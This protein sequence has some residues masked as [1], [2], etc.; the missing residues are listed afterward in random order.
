MVLPLIL[1][2][3]GCATPT[4]SDVAYDPATSGLAADNVQS[5]IDAEAAERNALAAEQAGS[6]AS[7]ATL[8]TETASLQTSVTALETD[9]ASIDLLV[10]ALDASL[11][12]VESELA[13]VQAAMACPTGTTAT[14]GIC[15]DED[16]RTP[17]VSGCSQFLEASE[18]CAAEGLRL[19]T[20]SE[21]H[22]ACLAAP[23]SLNDMAGNYEIVA[24][25]TS[26]SSF[27][28]AG[29]L[30]CNNFGE[31]SCGTDGNIGLA[32]AYRCCL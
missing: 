22:S 6:A 19:C 1:A 29:S 7:L 25:L 17:S 24:D 28:V 21:W 16:E 15:I 4:A 26:A 31:A 13:A 12:S 10:A 18:A 9:V 20:L 3:L 30:G 23:A 11:A 8:Q 32:L 14:N 27:V 2:T 5:A